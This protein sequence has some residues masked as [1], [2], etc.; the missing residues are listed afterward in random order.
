[1]LCP[2]YHSHASPLS[3]VPQSSVPAVD[4][5][6][7]VYPAWADSHADYKEL[8]AQYRWGDMHG[9]VL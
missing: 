6:V 2:S 3:L 7:D 1:M 4:V 8:M 5:G 9:H